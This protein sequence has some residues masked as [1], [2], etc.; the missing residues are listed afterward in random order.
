MELL[1]LTLV[2]SGLSRS[3]IENL[4]RGGSTRLNVDARTT[5]AIADIL[6]KPPSYAET[7][8]GQEDEEPLQQL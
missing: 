7:W 3:R 2:V 4:P 1:V 6:N 5:T 8:E